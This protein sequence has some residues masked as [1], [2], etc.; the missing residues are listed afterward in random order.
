MGENT[1][2]GPGT[3]GKGV[4]PR[5]A[6]FP[7]AKARAE[8]TLSRA[9][10]SV[11]QNCTGGTAPGGWQDRPD[12]TPRDVVVRGRNWKDKLIQEKFPGDEA[13]LDRIHSETGLFKHG[14][15]QQD[16]I[17]GLS[18]DNMTGNRFP[19]Y[20]HCGV[21]DVPLSP[22]AVGEHERNRTDGLNPEPAEHLSR[23]HRKSGSGIRKGSNLP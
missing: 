6:G 19:V 4:P 7:R 5:V 9:R 10:G 17:S 15:A 3:W 23:N 20:C 18:K 21:T 1:M 14:E 8:G 11:K 12:T 22:P 16:G 2:N 13:A